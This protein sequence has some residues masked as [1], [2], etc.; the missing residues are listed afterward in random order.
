MLQGT[1]R[2]YDRYG[3]GVDIGVETSISYDIQ[4]Q[5]GATNNEYIYNYFYSK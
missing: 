4:V 5:L 3:V 1:I 2:K